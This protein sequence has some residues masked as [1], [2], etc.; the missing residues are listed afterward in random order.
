M[1]HSLKGHGLMDYSVEIEKAKKLLNEGSFILCSV[2][3][4]MILEDILK[5]SLN[6]LYNNPRGAHYK[7]VIRQSYSQ[8]KKLTLGK[9]LINLK[10]T[11]AFKLLSDS[12]KIDIRSLNNIDF[13]LMVRIRN[14][15]AHEGRNDLEDGADAD[16][17][18]MYGYLLKL[19]NILAPVLNAFPNV[20]Q[21]KSPDLKPAK[22]VHRPKKRTI[23]PIIGVDD[24]NDESIQK[25]TI[26]VSKNKR[27]GKFFIFLEKVSTSESNYIIPDG[28]IK[29]LSSDLFDE[30]EVF[31][32]K[33]LLSNKLI[34]P[35][36]SE[37]LELY[38]KEKKINRI[39]HPILKRVSGGEPG[40]IKKYRKL[41]ES[42]NTVPSIMLRCIKSSGTIRWIDLKRIL[43]EK[44]KYKESGSFG[45][46]LRVLSIDGHINIDGSGDEK[47]IS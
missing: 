23:I 5:S 33:F 42:P 26:E 37:R 38:E 47:L 25:D 35:E 31:K 34:T 24:K 44:Y 20:P 41:L 6:N 8:N 32:K 19:L 22:V 45:A 7:K 1:L 43:I 16:A 28:K 36:Q 11:N 13:D 17:Y 29:V 12:Y 46:S 14:E 40:Y 39:D 30:V 9:L 4:G 3:C 2:Q 27:T 15:A 18:I 21:I 10:K